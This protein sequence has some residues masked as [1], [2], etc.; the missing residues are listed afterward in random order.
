LR[1]GADQ[2]RD[3]AIKYSIELGF[4]TGL[5]SSQMLN[6]HVNSLF[7]LAR[8]F[9]NTGRPYDFAQASDLANQVKNDIPVMLRERLT[10]PPDETYSIHRKLSGCF[11]LCTKLGSRIDCATPFNQYFK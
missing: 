1:A 8:P 9:R 5:E 2:D 4:L 7:L 3:S 6:A 11:L 10:P